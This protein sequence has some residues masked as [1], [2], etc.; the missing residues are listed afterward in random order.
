MQDKLTVLG[1]QSIR[2]NL[3]VANQG[4]VLQWNRI[5]TGRLLIIHDKIGCLDFYVS[6]KTCLL[7]SL[8]LIVHPQDYII[9]DQFISDHP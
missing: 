4:G 7:E 2:K 6:K 3:I 9:P 5:I 1:I 8:S